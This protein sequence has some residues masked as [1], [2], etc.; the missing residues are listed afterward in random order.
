VF[1]VCLL[2]LV[3]VGRLEVFWT[4]PACPV[5]SGV[6]GLGTGLTGF[7][8]ATGAY[9]LTAVKYNIYVINSCII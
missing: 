5:S 6:T 8:L 9:I 1:G 4:K 2:R 7:T 3:H